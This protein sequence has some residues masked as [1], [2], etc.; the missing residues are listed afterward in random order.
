MVAK[1][2]KCSKCLASFIRERHS[3][4]SWQKKIYLGVLIVFFLPRHARMLF[5]DETW[6]ALKTFV[7]LCHQ[8]IFEFF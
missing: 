4:K 8:I 3:W 2:N 1:N 5:P 7:I 6:K